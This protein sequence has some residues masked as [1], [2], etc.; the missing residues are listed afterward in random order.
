MV[1]FGKEIKIEEEICACCDVA[2]MH[3]QKFTERSTS[4]NILEIVHTDECGKIKPPT[5][6][7]KNYF[8][9]FIDDFSC[10]TVINLIAT[11]DEVT[12][13]LEEYANKV[14]AKFNHK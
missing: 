5:H 6:D 9:S 4:T 3:K 11:K 14:Q 1:D 13:K 8:V 12:L 7:G 2:K 10:F